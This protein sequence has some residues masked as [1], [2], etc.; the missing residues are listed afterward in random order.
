MKHRRFAVCALG[1]CVRVYLAQKSELQIERER[2]NKNA[3]VGSTTARRIVRFA[4][5]GRSTSTL[6]L[7]KTQIAISCC[8][9]FLRLQLPLALQ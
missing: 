4:C 5:G 8:C 7:T 1:V 3:R 2:E 6:A 9:C